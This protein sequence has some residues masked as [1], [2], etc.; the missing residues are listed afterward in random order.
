MTDFEVVDERI[1]WQGRVIKAGT[2]TYR[3]DNGSENT[4]D[5]IWHPGAVTIVP[6]DE[7][8][9]WLVGQ[10][11]EASHLRASLE[12]PAGKRDRQGE[13]LLELAKR[14]LIEEIGKEAGEWREVLEFFPTP[15]FCDEFITLYA[16]TDLSNA[17]GGAAP[18]EDE[19]IE[20]IAWPLT[21]IAGA[22]KATSDAKTLI[23]L[24]WLER[25]LSL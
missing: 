3:Y 10:P 12:I 17:A 24:L 9:V 11:R 18:E 13:P 25:E 16:A 8:N 22:I 23:G 21:D 1:H 15:G 7:T 4:F 6:Y 14:E 19:H 2:E 20:I 5:K